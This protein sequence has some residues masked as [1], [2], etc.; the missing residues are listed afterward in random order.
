M[1]KRVSSVLAALIV[2]CMTGMFF[3]IPQVHAEEKSEGP[4][5]NISVDGVLY[6]AVTNGTECI[7]KSANIDDVEVK[8]I[9]VNG[10]ELENVGTKSGVLD[11]QGRT[12]LE[13][14]CNDQGNGVWMIRLC[15]HD[16]DDPVEANH[17]YGFDITG[18]LLKK[19]KDSKLK[20]ETVV[21]V[22]NVKAASKSK[23]LLVSWKKADCSGYEIQCAQ[24]KAKL[25]KAAKIKVKAGKTSYKITK[26]KSAKKY[27]VRIRTYKKYY[28]AAGKEKI[29]CGKWVTIT[30]KTLK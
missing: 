23:A 21:N 27:Y 25:S 18:I 13:Y 7:I 4:V 9:S 30:A 5:I 20:D 28:D 2:L 11:S 10:H 24:S 12:V 22:K 1:K 16:V 6:E 29:V 17:G 15:Y 26:L 8:I 3:A 14:N 19:S